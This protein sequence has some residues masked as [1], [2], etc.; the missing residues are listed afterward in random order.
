MTTL[1]SNQ[2]AVIMLV[3]DTSEDIYINNRIIQKYGRS[4]EV[5]KFNMATDAIAYFKLNQD[6]LLKIP[7]VLFLDIH[8]PRMNAFE[9]M[10]EYAK[11]PDTLKSK[12]SVY[13]V[14]SSFDS[15]DIEKANANP[16]IK[17]FFEKPLTKE[18]LDKVL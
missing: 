1:L 14:S 5:M 4:N 7:D 3:D 6:N 13:I 17:N 10:D 18:T 8:M 15:R 9:F 16:D 12:C 11:L 2:P